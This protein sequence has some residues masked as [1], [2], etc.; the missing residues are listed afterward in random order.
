M[1]GYVREIKS[2]AQQVLSM[3]DMAGSFKLGRFK[4]NLEDELWTYGSVKSLVV[5]WLVDQDT[6][7]DKGNGVTQ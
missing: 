2:R 4:L 1:I 5:I 6:C 7:L 3:L